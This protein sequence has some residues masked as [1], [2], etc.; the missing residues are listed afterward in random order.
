V[1]TVGPVRNRWLTPGAIKLHVALALVVPVL[2]GLGWWQLQRALGGHAR[3]WA[4]AIQWPAFAAYAV[5]L[6]WKLLRERPE[7]RRPGD[8]EPVEEPADDGEG[9]GPRHITEP[10]AGRQ[11]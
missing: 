8:P 3:S 7:F 5:Y 2:L 1:D 9:P 4:Y 10:E 6:W 11:A